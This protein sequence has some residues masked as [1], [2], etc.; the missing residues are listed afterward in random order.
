[1][2]LRKI[3]H[4]VLLNPDQPLDVGIMGK[5][6][7]IVI[8]VD[9]LKFAAEHCDDNP[10]LE[11]ID[12]LQLCHDTALEMLKEEENG[13]TILT[14]MMDKAVSNAC[15]NGSTAFDYDSSPI[16]IR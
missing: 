5:C 15:D 16:P 8:G 14:D 9:T 12:T 7:I 4:S 6:F 10:R 13:S 11:V 2:K 1:M 3:K